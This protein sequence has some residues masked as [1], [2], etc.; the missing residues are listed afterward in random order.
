MMA[1]YVGPSGVDLVLLA[2]VGHRLALHQVQP[3][4]FNFLFATEVVPY[5]LT[6]ITVPL[7]AASVRKLNPPNRR[8]RLK[9]NILIGCVR[10]PQVF[11]LV[12]GV[13]GVAWTVASSELW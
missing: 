7:Y 6:H 11:L 13:A 3:Q 8:F 1:I 5:W 2:Q 12:T 9:Q 4:D 10:Q